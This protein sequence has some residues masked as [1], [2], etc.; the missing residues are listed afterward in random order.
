M[1]WDK[2]P[3]Y[4]IIISLI[5]K[6]LCDKNYLKNCHFNFSGVEECTYYKL[7]VFIHESKSQFIAFVEISILKCMFIIT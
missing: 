6:I 5:W 4:A 2:D 7:K 1:F 3:Q